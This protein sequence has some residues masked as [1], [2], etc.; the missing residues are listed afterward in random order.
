MG[1]NFHIDIQQNR[2]WAQWR[3]KLLW[4]L[5]RYYLVWG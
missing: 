2:E 5:P 4:M 1:A 3:G